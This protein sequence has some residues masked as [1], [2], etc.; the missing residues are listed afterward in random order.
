M[1][2]AIYRKNKNIFLKKMKCEFVCAT[3]IFFDKVETAEVNFN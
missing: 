2:F 1:N 3:I